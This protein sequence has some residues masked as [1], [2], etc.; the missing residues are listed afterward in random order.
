MLNINVDS[1][2]DYLDSNEL[3]RK[4]N[5]GEIL[6]SVNIFKIKR[7]MVGGSGD[8]DISGS[9]GNDL[10]WTGNGNNTVNSG[11]GN[12]FII[13]GSG[14][15]VI[16]AGS[17]NDM[18]YGG[19][20]DDYLDG[21]AGSDLLFAGAGNDILVG[22]SS[23]DMLGGGSGNDSLS[24]G[25][26]TDILWGAAGTDILEGGLG[27]DYYLWGSADGRDTIFG[28]SQD[29]VVLYNTKHDSFALSLSGDDLVVAYNS[30]NSI[31]IDNWK[32][33]T[34]ATNLFTFAAEYGKSYKVTESSGQLSWTAV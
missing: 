18:I 29:N 8:D 10:I 30:N 1:V 26:G 12:D 24:G 7:V 33:N 21:G 20:G 28:D 16:S 19:D 25:E 2:L 3:A 13:A 9:S 32:D 14:N 23:N 34:S 4:Y 22:G 6:K 17:G 11:T 15:D 31:T 5:V 27:S